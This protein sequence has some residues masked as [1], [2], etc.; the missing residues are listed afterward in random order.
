MDWLGQKKKESTI[1]K[2]NKY[3]FAETLIFEPTHPFLAE[4][5]QTASFSYVYHQVMC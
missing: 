1:K 4:Q 3:F 2:P 5:D